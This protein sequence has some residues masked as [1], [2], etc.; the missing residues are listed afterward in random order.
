MPHNV[1][2]SI[3]SKWNDPPPRWSTD[4]KYAASIARSSRN[5]DNQMTAA[6]D[7]GKASP[8]YQ[9][10]NAE[11]VD[12]DSLEFCFMDLPSKND[13]SG[14]FDALDPIQ[15][16][17]FPALSQADR[18][19]VNPSHLDKEKKVNGAGA[20]DQLPCYEPH[21]SHILGRRYELGIGLSSRG[22]AAA[23]Q[24]QPRSP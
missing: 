8:D 12:M 4:D 17:D 7:N 22:Y 3:N 23:T 18:E 9:S 14:L 2:A 6:V 13:D 20:C 5:T 10:S 1:Q 21:Y 11:F 19:S 15:E 16:G 24:I